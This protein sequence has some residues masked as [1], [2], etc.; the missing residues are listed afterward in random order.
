M[1]NE[2]ITKINKLL[3]EA[4]L[5]QAAIKPYE[6]NNNINVLQG[7]IVAFS[8][9]IEL[10]KT[11]KENLPECISDAAQE[12][13]EQVEKYPLPLQEYCI[14]IMDAF[15]AGILW[16]LEQ[17]VTYETVMQQDD[18]DDLVP[19]LSDCSDE[20]SIDEKVIVQIRRR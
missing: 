17:G 14:Q 5:E 20:F 3:G 13:Y 9:I 2:I 12:Y 18:C 7:K 6:L 16:I 8:E 19:S 10:L 4:K 11:V 15:K 1:L